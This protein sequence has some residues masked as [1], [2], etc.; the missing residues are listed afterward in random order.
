MS[1][2]NNPIESKT[3]TIT[4]NSKACKDNYEKTKRQIKPV[5]FN[6][7]TEKKLLDVANSF[8]F[9]TWVKNML[10]ALTPAE[11]SIVKGNTNPNFI[12]A[13]LIEQAIEDG[14]FS[15]DEYLESKGQKIVEIQKSQEINYDESCQLLDDDYDHS[16]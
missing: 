9:S 1:T 2:E 14:L 13:L 5:S 4:P 7:E 8:N 11:I 15:L 12:P 10:G 16:Y 3:L 6:K